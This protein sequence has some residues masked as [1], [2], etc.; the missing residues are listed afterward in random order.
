MLL[1][2][3]F[4]DPKADG[5]SLNYRLARG[6]PIKMIQRILLIASYLLQ[7]LNHRTN[8]GRLLTLLLLSSIC[9]FLWIGISHSPPLHHAT[10]LKPCKRIS[11]AE[12]L[13][14]PTTR[15]GIPMI[16]HQT[17]LDTELPNAYH[18]LIKRCRRL[19]PYFVHVLWTDEDLK[20]FLYLER[21]E[22]VNLLNG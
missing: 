1:I 11:S 12:L 22:L 21:P 10:N 9:V 19:N 7:V 16:I 20:T 2:G 8:K 4:R 15:N 3:V 14:V 17:Y 18:D 5:R 6:L 13:R